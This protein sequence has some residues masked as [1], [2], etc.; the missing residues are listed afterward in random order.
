MANL[1]LKGYT[2]NEYGLFKLE[3]GKR[4]EKL[5]VLRKK[6]FLKH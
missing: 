4:T 3:N 2:L 1:Q 5:Y 6:I